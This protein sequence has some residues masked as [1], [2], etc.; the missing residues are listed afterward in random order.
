MSNKEFTESAQFTESALCAATN[1][2]YLDYVSINAMRLM[3]DSGQ[4][5]PFSGDDMAIVNHIAECELDCKVCTYGE[6]ND[7]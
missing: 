5:Y 1:G 4:E 3:S 6:K 7:N 2:F